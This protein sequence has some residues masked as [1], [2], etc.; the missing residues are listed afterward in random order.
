MLTPLDIE[1]KKFSKQIMNGYSV[2]EV[3]EFLDEV[4]VEYEKV[5]KENIELKK[6]AEDL[7]T[8]VGEYKNIE[9]TLQNTLV[10]AQKT[11]D[12]IQAVAKQ[13]AEQIIKDAE[14][15]AKS[16]I[17][18]INAK[19]IAKQAEY[20][21]MKKQFEVYKAKQESLLIGQLEI[22]KDVNED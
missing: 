12:E 20:D 2:E 7:N 14:F 19:L 17:E 13:K 11:A 15:T 22:L 21:A 3:D 6:H 8:D 1:N 10:M 16:S 9:S 4:T 18:E 5:Y